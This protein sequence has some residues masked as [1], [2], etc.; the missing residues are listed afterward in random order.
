MSFKQ[1]GVLTQDEVYSHCC[2]VL[3]EVA[4][5]LKSEQSSTVAK[6]MSE[7]HF[8]KQKAHQYQKL[9]STMKVRILYA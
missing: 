6:Q 8:L 9:V 4:K 1:E 7:A 3:G 5:E 2:R